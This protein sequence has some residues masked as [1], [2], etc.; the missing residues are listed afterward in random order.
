MAACCTEWLTVAA[1]KR[2]TGRGPITAKTLTDHRNLI[3]GHIVPRI[4]KVRVD[5]LTVG[6]IE[7]MYQ[8]MADAGLSQSTI[9]HTRDAL[10]MSLDRAVKL[11]LI[12]RNVS[13]SA[14]LPKSG[15][16]G[17]PQVDDGGRGHGVYPIPE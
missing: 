6:Q 8:D 9:S 2:R 11:G 15:A 17:A 1:P 12:P 4:G 7:S 16:T 13:K 3:D 10:S 14:D 5:R